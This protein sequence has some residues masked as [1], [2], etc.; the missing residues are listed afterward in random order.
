MKKINISQMLAIVLC[1]SSWLAPDVLATSTDTGAWS[2]VVSRLDEWTDA[3]VL[4]PPAHITCHVYGQGKFRILLRT[5]KGVIH[6]VVDAPLEDWVS[7]NRQLREGPLSIRVESIP[8][9]K[10]PTP[11]FQALIA[12][13][14]PDYIP[15][16]ADIHNPIYF[17]MRNLADKDVR[18]V[19]RGA[20]HTLVQPTF[21]LGYLMADGLHEKLD[22]PLKAKESTGMINMSRA[23]QNRT[24]LSFGFYDPVDVEIEF[25]TDA[26]GT[27]P[28]R[29]Y[30]VKSDA[31][32]VPGNNI[33]TMQYCLLFP[34]ETKSPDDDKTYRMINLQELFEQSLTALKAVDLSRPVPKKIWALAN[35]I[36]DRKE[37][38][39]DS[40]MAE[41]K[42]AREI[43]F[44]GVF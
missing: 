21:S 1:I 10:I 30:K 43:G 35:N 8:D 3:P 26:A 11:K 28:L 7:F 31:L 37:A 27:K 2:V 20:R 6:R 38:T 17:R 29:N 15:D 14:N 40:L 42:L 36:M 22:G 9:P 32:A 13:S 19:V 16:L 18:T 34:N 5:S 25:F 44:N 24:V 41:L 4:P 33:P 39:T 23:V 12:A